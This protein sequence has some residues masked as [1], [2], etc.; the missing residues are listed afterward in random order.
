MNYTNYS[1]WRLLI[2][3]YDQLNTIKQLEN[4]NEAT[5]LN[6]KLRK[7]H[8]DLLVPSADRNKLDFILNK[9]QI[10]YKETVANV[11]ELIDEEER[12]NTREK[13]SLR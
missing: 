1:V 4:V 6:H 12:V 7:G 10:K 9:S 3:D 8:V 5:V 2:N 11:Q 13:R